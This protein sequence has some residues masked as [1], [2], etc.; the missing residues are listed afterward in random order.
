MTGASRFVPPTFRTLGSFA[1]PDF[2]WADY[3][4]YA[5]EDSAAKQAQN[6]FQWWNALLNSL[7]RVL[8]TIA[9]TAGV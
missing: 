3:G 6:S 1:E 9:L 2:L 4:M 7:A 5:V 8:L